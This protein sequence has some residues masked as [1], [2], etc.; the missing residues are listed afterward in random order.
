MSSNFGRA[1]PTAYALLLG[2][3]TNASPEKTADANKNFLD[4]RLESSAASG[5]TR[6]MYMKLYFE[7]AGGGDVVR[8]YG[9][10]NAVGV[11]AGGT[12]NGVHATMEVAASSA[13]V[14]G[15]G[16]AVRAT[17]AAASQSRTLGGTLSALQLDSDIGAS[18]TVPASWS[19]IRLTKSGSVDLTT[20]MAITDDQCLKG[21]GTLAGS[22]GTP[23][24]AL[25]CTMPN[26][27]VVYIPV[28]AA[29]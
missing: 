7:G 18:N 10:A 22:P 1:D 21:N 9:V 16:N 5:D 2:T 28:Y 4:F 27:A 20:F 24:D 15:A 3:G 29:G 19:F 8:A 17:L 25:K 26:G 13:S 6:G 12:V 11:A 14:S 23:T